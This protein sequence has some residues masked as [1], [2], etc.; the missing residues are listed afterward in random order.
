MLGYGGLSVSASMNI[1]HPWKASRID[2]DLKRSVID[3]QIPPD[4]LMSNLCK[5]LR[6][7]YGP[8]MMLYPVNPAVLSMRWIMLVDLPKIWA[9]LLM[10][11]PL[12]RSMMYVAA[13]RLRR[14]TRIIKTPL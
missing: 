8:P 6:L 9:N 4:F 5:D 2:F 3:A 1:I 14:G 11:Y 10:L 13:S 12:R 7:S